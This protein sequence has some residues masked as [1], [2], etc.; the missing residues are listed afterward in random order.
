MLLKRL[1]GPGLA[2]CTYSWQVY[3]F[4]LRILR[5]MIRFSLDVRQEVMHPSNQASLFGVIAFLKTSAAASD[6]VE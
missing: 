4:V 6:V 1:E 3:D 5:Q 2:Q